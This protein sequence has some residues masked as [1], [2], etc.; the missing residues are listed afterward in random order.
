MSGP[1]ADASLEGATTPA[2][3]TRWPERLFE[4]FRLLGADPASASPAR[5]EAW[6]LVNSLLLHYLRL[7]SR[8]R[9]SVSEVDREDIAAEKT[10]DLLSRIESGEWDP[11]SHSGLPGFLSTVARNGLIDTLRKAGRHTKWIEEPCKDSSDDAHGTRTPSDGEWAADPVR[12][13][14]DRD[15]SRA[16]RDCVENL[17]PKARRIWFYRVLYDLPSREIATHPSVGLRPGNVDVILQRC[18]GAVGDC[19]ARK[20]YG[21][22][23]LRPGTYTELCRAFLVP[24][25]AEDQP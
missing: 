20:G 7:H 8:G 22:Q 17:Q 6:V 9:R 16:L 1:R 23:D 18:R 13:A 21:A 14:E 15:F 2:A 5:A 25:T 12:I 10:L 3:C 19:L 11:G 24:G 4:L